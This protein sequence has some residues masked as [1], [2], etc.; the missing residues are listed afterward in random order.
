MCFVAQNLFVKAEVKNENI[1]EPSCNSQ[2]ERLARKLA[3]REAVEHENRIQSSKFKHRV[4]SKY[5]A[6]MALIFFDPVGCEREYRR[7]T[8]RKEQ[9]DA[10]TTADLSLAIS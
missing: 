3:L 9:Q 5:K 4:E 6:V 1:G 2:I 7:G 8:M 10:A